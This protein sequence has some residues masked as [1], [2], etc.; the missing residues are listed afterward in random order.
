[1]QK[2]LIWD[3]NLFIKYKDII[4]K[5]KKDDNIIIQNAPLDDNNKNIENIIKNSFDTKI[6]GYAHWWE[7]KSCNAEDRKNKWRWSQIPH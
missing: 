5:L 6:I 2:K 4:D 3:V 1:M 7:M